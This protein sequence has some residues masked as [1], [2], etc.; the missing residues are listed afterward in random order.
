MKEKKLFK[1]KLVKKPFGKKKK[2]CESMTDYLDVAID[3]VR[4]L[5][6]VQEHWKETGMTEYSVMKAVAELE[7]FYVADVFEVYQ[8]QEKADAVGCGKSMLMCGKVTHMN[9][10]DSSLC[11]SENQE[12][13]ID[14]SKAFCLN[15]MMC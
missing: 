13:V 14:C 10:I 12:Q 1:I 5:S 9:L 4:W 11:Y 15:P 3:K 8:K 6:D 7:F 2:L